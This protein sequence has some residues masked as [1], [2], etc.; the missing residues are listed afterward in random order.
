MNRMDAI[1]NLS[2]RLASKL[3][4][5]IIDR[6]GTFQP[7]FNPASAILSALLSRLPILIECRPDGT[8]DLLLGLITSAV[9]GCAVH[10]FEPAAPARAVPPGSVFFVRNLNRLPIKVMCEA[11]RQIA[12]RGDSPVLTIASCDRD[13]RYLP[14]PETVRDLFGISTVLKTVS[15]PATTGKTA[16]PV[17]PS[18]L[19]AQQA[20]V[21]AIKLPD[22]IRHYLV[23][24]IR[25]TRPGGSEH[26][27]VC[28]RAEKLRG[29]IQT[30]ASTRSISSLAATAQALA[31]MNGRAEVSIEDIKAAFLPV[32]E[33]RIALTDWAVQRRVSVA[34]ALAM[35]VEHTPARS[36]L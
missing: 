20:A 6:D 32:L 3:D 9:K 14:L 5:L 4:R 22:Q 11:L 28:S 18:A 33:H 24:L 25:A 36:I 35:I 23:S 27:F 16:R 1:T 10:E 13:E 7:G 17:S 34:D 21:G 30:G 2:A 26:S 15:S 19:A 29:I 8:P 31:A 12:A